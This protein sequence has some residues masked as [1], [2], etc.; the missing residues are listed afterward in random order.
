MDHSYIDEHNIIARYGMGKLS[1]EECVSFEEHFVD[2]PQCQEQ[3]ETTQDFRQAFKTVAAEDAIKPHL[4][5]GPGWLAVFNWRPALVA[6]AA[7]AVIF[8]VPSFFLIRELRLAHAELSQA[9]AAAASHPSAYE[10]QASAE[11]A[12][13][14]PEPHPASSP[15]T[16]GATAVA[17]NTNA[18]SEHTS[19]EQ[20]AGGQ[21]AAGLPAVASIFALVTVRG[22]D[23]ND[24]EPVN[25]VVIS[26]SS[27]WVVLSVDRDDLQ[28]LRNYRATLADSHGRVLWQLGNLAPVSS[29]ALGISVPFNLL[30]DGDYLL[31]LE[32]RS[33]EAGSAISRIYPFRV[34]I[35]Q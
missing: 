18:S 21:S 2:C 6:V 1:S 8:V 16:G 29:N 24:S 33:R 25:Q 14:L 26:R 3:L 17:S 4:A 7:C 15:R 9:R 31:T 5:T 12:K 11:S 19:G 20:T 23:L 34:K 10:P 13:P 30:H 28:D 22:G 27:Q 32:G 35:K